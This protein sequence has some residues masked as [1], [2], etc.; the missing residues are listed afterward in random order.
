MGYIMNR[1]IRLVCAA[2]VALGSSAAN[3]IAI[4]TVTTGSGTFTSQPNVCTV[5]FNTPASLSSCVGAIYTGNG[6][7]LSHVVTGDLANQYAQP[8]N[9][10]TPYLTVGG[11]IGDPVVITL[12][13]GANYFGF[14]AGSIDTYNSITFTAQGGSAVTLTGS[15]IGAFLGGPVNQTQA[16][17][18]NVFTDSLFTSISLMSSQAA[19]E[20]DNHAF[21]IAFPSS[22]P[23]PASAALLGLGAVAFAATRRRRRPA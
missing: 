14:Y 22:V 20:T 2:L 7:I 5:D 15:Q 1:R 3:A 19:F 21:G 16:G 13:V 12:S 9:D 18:F 23:E 6:G 17:Y 4:S 10:P 11:A 8:A